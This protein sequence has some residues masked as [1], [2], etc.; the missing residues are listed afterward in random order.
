MADQKISA[1]TT[2]AGLTGA[3]VVP[4]VQ[5]GATV[6]ANVAWLGPTVNVASYGVTGNGV[7][8][9]TTNIQSAL[10]AAAGKSITF[11]KGSYVVSAQLTISAGTTLLFDNATFL[12]NAAVS[13][14]I[15]TWSAAGVT[16]LGKVT[17]NS[18]S[19][20]TPFFVGTSGGDRFRADIHATITGANTTPS[21][22]NYLFKITQCNGVRVGGYI[23]TTGNSPWLVWVD[24]GSKIEVSDVITAPIT[25]SN[26]AF[27]VVNVQERTGSGTLSQVSIHDCIIDGGSVLG[28]TYG[29]IVVG[30]AT[31]AV[32]TSYVTIADCSV[33]NTTSLVDGVDVVLA[34]YVTVANCVFS[35]CLDGI[36]VSG[37]TAVTVSNCV[38]VL[39]RGVGY[40]IGDSSVTADTNSVTFTNC[41]AYGCGAGAVGGQ[42]FIY[43]PSGH[44]TN[45]IHIDSCI[46]SCLTVSN[47][48]LQI[49]GPGGVSD[50]QITGGLWA[51]W[52][53]AAINDAVGSLP[54][55]VSY[56]ARNAV[57]I[58]PKGITSSPTVPASTVALTN[59]TGFDCM[60]IV[61]TG[62]GVTVSG[63][64][65]GAQ[66]T[67]IACGASS[68]TVPIWMPVGQSIT[69][70]YAGGTPTWGW[71]GA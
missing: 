69:L 35:A 48:A 24:R 56:L 64:S 10:T 71:F 21:S 55:S 22:S 28:G 14:G 18:Q 52:A 47:Y 9:D 3:E 29:A 58:N 32:T 59:K 39:C 70:T 50:I 54:N 11:P 46:A 51:G 13:A 49:T 5:S 2:S 38:A 27:G 67:G 4:V 16:V 66:A 6:K 40:A 62:G 20:A 43:A 37:S 41:Q 34:Q 17:V 36:S 15:M 60:V 26:G 30:T 44:T 1:L 12:V 31:T 45:A 57:G 65:I 19:N 25:V 68:Q 53:T 7:T 23:T 42:F 8:D 63:V 33:I 61:Y